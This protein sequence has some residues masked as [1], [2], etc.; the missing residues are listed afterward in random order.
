MTPP[1]SPGGGAPLDQEFASY[2]KELKSK[3]ILGG[4]RATAQAVVVL[5]LHIVELRARVAELEAKVPR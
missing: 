4:S 2:V 1:R 5:A 3:L